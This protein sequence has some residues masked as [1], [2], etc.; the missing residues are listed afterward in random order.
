MGTKSWNLLVIQNSL[1]EKYV[2]IIGYAVLSLILIILF[3]SFD[4]ESI[5][6]DLS[7]K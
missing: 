6:E 1:G 4:C 7:L 5:T 2:Y 3:V